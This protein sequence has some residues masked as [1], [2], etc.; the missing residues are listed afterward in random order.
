MKRAEFGAAAF[1]LG[2]VTGAA[3]V[4][5][6]GSTWLNARP[7]FG[8]SANVVQLISA[9][10]LFVGIA[11]A[12]W[13]RWHRTCKVPYCL[14]LGQ[15]EVKGTTWKVCPVHHTKDMRWHYVVARLHHRKHPER[16]GHGDTHL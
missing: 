4:V 7:E 9:P 13:L 11:M 1:A 3:L 8:A 12:A 10:G 5:A 14:R 16:A 15:F 2:L 6:Y